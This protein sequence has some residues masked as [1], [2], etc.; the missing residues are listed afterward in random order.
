MLDFKAELHF[1][2]YSIEPYLKCFHDMAAKG[3]EH[4]LIQGVN[5]LSIEFLKKAS[6]F[7]NNQKVKFYVDEK[8]EKTLIPEG[9][10]G[11]FDINDIEVILNFI[12][13]EELLSV[14][15]MGCRSIS[16]CVIFSPI[17]NHY[18]K[19]RPVFINSIPKGGTHLLFECVR[20]MGFKEP[21]TLDLPDNNSEILPGHFYNLQHAK[22]DYFSR[23]YSNIYNLISAF[24]SSV[25]LFI[26][27]D[28]RDIAVSLAY[29]LASQSQYHILFEH[30]KDLS[31][32]DRLLSVIQ[33]TYPLSV[34]FNR[35]FSF[36]GNI[37]DLI[38]TYCDWIENPFPNT[39][40]LKFEDLIGAE[41]GGDSAA[42]LRTI[43]EI[44]LALHV[45]GKPADFCGKIFST[46][47]LTFRKGQIGDYKKEFS[48]KTEKIFREL[49]QDFMEKSGY[50]ENSSEEARDSI[51]DRFKGK[52]AFKAENNLPV[53][54]ERNFRGYNLIL[55]NENIYAVSQLLGQ[56]DLFQVSAKQMNE[57]IEK[58][59]LIKEKS[60]ED[61]KE[62]IFNLP[63]EVVKK[64][65]HM[66]FLEEGVEGYNIFEFGCC[67]Y[68]INQNLGP[69][70]LS[71]LQKEE[72]DGLKDKFD[73]LVGYSIPE[74]KRMAALVYTLTQCYDLEEADHVGVEKKESKENKRKPNIEFH[75][76]LIEENIDGFNIIKF[77]GVFY[78]VAQ[79]FEEGEVENLDAGKI[80]N[81]Q[82]RNQIAVGQTLQQAKDIIQIISSD[83]FQ[84]SIADK[85]K[86]IQ[87]GYQGFNIVQYKGVFYVV[88]QGVILDVEELTSI[89]IVDYQSKFQMAVGDS[90]EQA[91][92]LT[93]FL[94]S[95][96]SQVEYDEM[97]RSKV[98]ER[99]KKE[100]EV[101]KKK[102]SELE[103]KL[104]NYENSVN[105]LKFELEKKSIE[106]QEIEEKLVKQSEIVDLIEDELKDKNE[107][108]S[109]LIESNERKDEEIKLAN[110]EL[111]KLKQKVDE[112]KKQINW[113]VERIESLLK[114]LCN[115]NEEIIRLNEAIR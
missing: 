23:Q 2:E 56:L 43:W 89:L 103:I 55:F 10:S 67:F 99:W 44:Q 107:K 40:V 60:L 24:S 111:N 36:N 65:A 92:E 16:H 81:Y 71:L 26:Y 83:D 66:R 88:A 102:S 73:I 49:P 38:N 13:D 76:R 69:I 21:D 93:G 79:G 51:K 20:A 82:S 7:E 31:P 115:K 75:S 112:Y 63:P 22:K 87:E 64:F 114:M 85:P 11:S 5:D 30:M 1:V 17:T 28:P 39:L 15:L 96:K 14:S 45:D 72:L 52:I 42:Q 61:M 68:A 4:F 19:K 100:N 95:R 77:R 33:G 113:D 106:R 86:I 29:Y 48:E 94:R 12:D 104:A 110:I 57:L 35:E 50:S 109:A 25:V 37:R 9:F 53:L 74:V 59:L 18:Y 54:I 34:F 47:A 41:G 90:L 8:K 84:Y 3:K 91:K 98:N 6:K 97:R 46:K 62:T 101:L 70:D 80:I 78:V 32:E 108:L 27:R 105:E 58:N